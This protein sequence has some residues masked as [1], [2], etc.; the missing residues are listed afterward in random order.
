MKLKDNTISLIGI[1]TELMFAMIV[2]EQ[3]YQSHGRELVVTSV[4]DSRHSG[5]SLHYSGCAFDARTNYFIE[6]EADKVVTEIKEKL[7]IDYD[8]INEVD[9]IHVE[10][11]PRR[12]V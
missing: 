6:G 5:T 12:K 7:N 9:H 1:R 4:N 10:W 3:V 8:V 2:T 11:Q